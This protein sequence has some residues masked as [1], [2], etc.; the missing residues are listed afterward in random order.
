MERRG[1]G[2]WARWEKE[3]VA[4]RKEERRAAAGDGRYVEKEKRPKRTM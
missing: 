4:Y 3:S 1:R 2:G